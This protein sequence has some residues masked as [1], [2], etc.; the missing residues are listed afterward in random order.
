MR[1]SLV[2]SRAVP[3]RFL[4]ALVIAA[5]SPAAA[6]AQVTPPSI[7][8]VRVRQDTTPLPDALVRSQRV[9]RV[10]DARGLARLPLAAGAHRLVVGKLGFRPE[11]LL[12]VVAAGRDT[13]IDVPLTERAAEVERMVVSATRS[14]R[15]I[16]DEP[17]RVEVVAGDEVAEKLQQQPG[18]LRAVLSEINGVRVQTT[19]A[20]T[21]AAG[22]RIEGLRARYTLL[23]EDGLPL[24]GSGGTGLEALQIPPLD[25]G[26]V[27]V[28][29]GAASALY[30]SSALGGVVDLVSRR[31]PAAGNAREVI[32]NQ[33][34]QQGS[35]AAI[36]DARQLGEQW[37]LSLLAS[38]H[39]Q[40]ERDF[41]GDGWREVPFYQ[42]LAVQPRLYFTSP[43]GSTFFGTIQALGETRQG[44]DPA[45]WLQ[46]LR[47]RR[48]NG[49][50]IGRW[51]WTPR[52][53]VTTR[54]SGSAD[55]RRRSVGASDERERRNTEFLEVSWARDGGTHAP[56]LG[57]S[58]QHDGFDAL[59]VD[60]VS[61]DFWVP[62]LFAQD[63]WS[64]VQ[65]FALAASVRADAHSDYG[66]HVNPRLSALVRLARLWTVR[67]SAGTGYAAPTPMVE[68]TD[69]TGLRWLEP[70]AGLTAERARS[71]SIDLAGEVGVLR[72][73]GT[74]W[75][76]RVEHPLS[77]ATVPSGV[78]GVPPRLRLVSAAQPVRANGAEA[79]VAWSPFAGASVTGNYAYIQATEL[80]VDAG[81][82]R[83]VPLNPKQTAELDLVLTDEDA[84]R[85]FA[86]EVFHTGV[87]A[88]EHDP[89]RER[90]PAYTTVGFLAQQ[91]VGQVVVY[92]NGE[93]LGDVRQ[94]RYE[95]L[96]LPSLG[97]GARRTRDVWGPLQ[98][99]LVNAG[100]RV[101]F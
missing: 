82:R 16:A 99:R 34:S 9:V 1:L 96:L 59:D 29:K 68:E 81:A 49:G 7:V 5:A 95:S 62:S 65:R 50:V 67:L 72:L 92:L 71:G 100:V 74:L 3:N 13:T 56:V 19:S 79:L 41:D 88:L 43:S 25:I 69:E 78:A 28:I 15:T 23:L 20:G 80:D 27:E 36:W 91:R 73:T 84:G 52:D 60:G 46:A 37:G 6:R 21:G 97:P 57:A 38:A 89:D 58:L 2:R 24:Y 94:W 55:W 77:V 83:D 63:T 98:G 31:P 17:L 85:R 44:G 86:M 18:N 54:A 87:Q 39:R 48:A 4:A 35:D 51:R 40:A 12:V 70:M 42:R 61:Y 93:N 26:Q 76:S 22:I 45:S 64:P 32:V 14:D 66:T 101:A 53:L 8:T 11:T 90:S 33:T 10:T 30:G 47:T 75:S